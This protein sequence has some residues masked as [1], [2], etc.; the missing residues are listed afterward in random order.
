MTGPEPRRESAMRGYRELLE[1]EV[2]MAWRSH[3]TILVCALFVVVGIATPLITRYLPELS[4]L[5]SGP[6]AE[7]GP[8]ETGPA[9]VID[10][11]VRNLAQLGT[12][13]VVVLAMG[14]I[15]R[16]RE[17][18]R[19][20]S[21]LERSGPGAVVLAKFVAL[22]MLLALATGLAVLAAWLYV[23]LVFGQQPPLPWIQLAVLVWLWLAV[24]EAITLLGSAFAPSAIGAAAVGVGGLAALQLASSIPAL[25]LWLPA[26]LLEVARAAAMEELSPDLDPAVT[27][28]VS[29]AGIGAALGMAWLRLGRERNA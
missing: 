1:D 23:A 10:A 2:V 24:V 6:D 9:D 28:A 14:A 19:L 13:P 25:N 27:I 12:L 4:R 29:L 22:A 20:P 15:A 11:L 5:L 7:L 18:R 3:R 8:V 17:E 21:V 16:A 26:G